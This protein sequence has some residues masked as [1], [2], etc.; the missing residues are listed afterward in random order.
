MASVRKEIPL[1]A[2]VATVWDALRDVGA[3]HTRLVPGFVTDCRLDGDARIVTFANGQ[4]ARERIVD[5]SDADRR[6]VWAISDP[7]FSH[8]RAAA[9]VFPDGAHGSRLVWISDFLPHALRD[10]IDG[11]M[12]LGASAMQKAFAEEAAATRDP[13]SRSRP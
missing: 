7:P 8:Y 6:V 9:Q 3:L 13:A 12:T 2:G 10:R 4:V 5:V 11:M 1:A